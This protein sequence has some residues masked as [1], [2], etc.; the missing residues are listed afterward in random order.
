M[1]E[2]FYTKNL[3]SDLL[4]EAIQL[5][6]TLRTVLQG[7]SVSINQDGT[8][9]PDNISV[10]FTRALLSTEQDEITAIINLMGSGTYDLEVRK[11]IEENVMNRVMAQGHMLLAKFAANNIYAG[12]NQTQV[13]ALATQY[14]ELIHSL[15]TGSLTVTY[16]IFLAM[17]PDANITQGEIDEFR[18][19][20]EIILGM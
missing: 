11:S 18:L 4:K 17:V 1:E 7:V 12:K 19:R 20:L 5:R 9:N 10:K 14:P 2:Y 15:I 16:G 8:V 6:T 13:E 3:D